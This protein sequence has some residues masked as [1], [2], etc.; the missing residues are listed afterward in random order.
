MQSNCL[1]D[2]WIIAMLC[3]ALPVHNLTHL[4]EDAWQHECSLN[5]IYLHFLLKIVFTN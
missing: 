3:M 5:D 1:I 2:L 4:H